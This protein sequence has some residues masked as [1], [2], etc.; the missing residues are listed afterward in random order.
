MSIGS[1]MVTP[2]PTAAPLTAGDHRL[3][4]F[5]DAQ[6]EPPAAVALDAAHPGF[7]APGIG[8]GGMIEGGAAGGQVRAGAEAAPGAGDDHRLDRVVGVGGV[9]GG[10]HVGHHLAGEGVQLVGPVEGDGR[11]AV[12]HV[13]EQGLESRLGHGASPVAF[14]PTR[15]R[16]AARVKTRR[17]STCVIPAQVIPAQVERSAT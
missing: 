14:S 12:L 4:A 16:Y 17:P 2:T 1:C 11:D 7:Q 3:E 13:I 6:G 8:A 9:E 15:P 5:E 10:D